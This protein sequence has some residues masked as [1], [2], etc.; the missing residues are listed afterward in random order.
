MMDAIAQHYAHHTERLAGLFHGESPDEPV[1][2]CGIS[3]WIG[4][5]EH[6]VSV[7]D[8]PALV[9][10]VVEDL[11]AQREHVTRDH[12]FRPLIIEHWGYGTHFVDAVFG[13]PVTVQADGNSWSK[14]LPSDV[15]TLRVPD[16]TQSAEVQRMVAVTDALVQAVETAGDTFITLPV[17]SSP[18]NVAVNLYGERFLIALLEAPDAA[19]HDLAVITDTIIALHRLYRVHI[20]PAVARVSVAACRFM[21][22]GYGLIDGCTTQLV[23]PAVYDRSIAPQ[24][25]RI[26]ADYPHGGMMHLCGAS[27]QHIPA[28]RSMPAL[29]AVQLNDRA[30]DA[31]EAYYWG[32]R[33]DQVLYVCPT[34]AMP[35]ERILRI[36]QGGRRV[37]L[38]AEDLSE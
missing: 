24:D 25:N 15:G 12:V 4:P 13:A 7:S 2:L 18:L 33:N 27:E 5:E 31:F 38:A 29:R 1:Q 37:V 6:Q 36:S 30:T 32:L 17:L 20:P 35:V 14:E 19:E 22:E 34:H 9:R 8:I 21:P 3:R 16:I 23:S 11:W 26:L 10:S 28:L